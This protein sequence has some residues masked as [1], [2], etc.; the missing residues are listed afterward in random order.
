MTVTFLAQKSLKVNIADFCLKKNT[1][2]EKPK[3]PKTY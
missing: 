3:T 2:L 1:A